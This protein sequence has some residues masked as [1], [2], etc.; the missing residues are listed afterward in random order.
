[1]C[2]A[3]G[4]GL[5]APIPDRRSRRLAQRA[6]SAVG[7]AARVHVSKPPSCTDGGSDGWTGD[8]VGIW[9][10]QPPIP[11]LEGGASNRCPR[12]REVGRG[13]VTLTHR[14]GAKCYTLL[15]GWTPKVTLYSPDG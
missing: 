2:P 13:G 3:T 4:T 9:P 14:M 15:T 1:M 11:G 7:S 10:D 8:D 6:A 5:L 12:G